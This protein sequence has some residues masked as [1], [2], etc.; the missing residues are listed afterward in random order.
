MKPDVVIGH[1]LGELA[2]AQTAG[3]FGLEDGLRFVMKRGQS[4]GSVPELGAMAAV[5]ASQQRVEEAISEYNA[6]SDCAD[7]NISVDNGVHQV[8]SGPALAVQAMVE[9]FEAEEVRVRPLNTS[10]A[11]H[12]ALVEPALDLLGTA[13]GSVAV[14]LPS[15]AMISNVTGRALEE[16]ETLDADYWR[17]HARQT[18]QFR[19]GIGALAELGVDLAIEVGPGAVLGPLLSLVWPGPVDIPEPPE[20]PVVLQSMTRPRNEEPASVSE[21]AFLNAVAGAY[22]A[23]LEISF[24]GLFAN[25]E[26]RKIELPGYPFQRERFWIEESRRRRVTDGHPLLGTRHESPRGE[27][28]FE[29]EVS[30]NDPSWLA[31]H[32]VFE[33]VIMPGAMYGAMAAAAALKEGAGSVEMEDLQLHN[34]MVFAQEESGSGGRR[35]QAV[36]NN[37]EAGRSRQLEIFSKGDGEDAWTLHAEARLSF[38]S[39]TRGPASRVDLDALRSG[40]SPLDVP[41]FYRARAE[42]SIHLG[43][44]L[45]TL[46]S[47]WAADGEAVGELALPEGVE[48]GSI[49]LHPLLLDG[50][51]QVMSSARHSADVESGEAYLPFGWERLWISGALPER[52]ICHARLR[53]DPRDAGDGAV[54]TREVLAGDFTIYN[55][56]GVE[57]GG[58]TGYAVKRATRASLLSAAEG[59]QDLSV[60]DYM[61]G[62]SRLK[63]G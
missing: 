60:R 43:P 18:V 33:R 42:S 20:A 1:S 15:V 45:R 55:P 36:I 63:R 32:K 12:S 6:T 14:S 4:L 47:L 28:T 59:I 48:Q 5:F 44:S 19:K 24:A 3:V 58:M 40:L 23:G 50:C 27:V 30:S 22:E 17:R 29:A 13:Y 7:M 51:F 62:R 9:R 61:A 54:E 41:G 21:D 53:E 37:T 10:Q 52:I 35:I 25:E 38:G 49:D 57:I 16:G 26:R 56:E 39:R 2:A 8:I 34:A 31:D 46:Q 11:F